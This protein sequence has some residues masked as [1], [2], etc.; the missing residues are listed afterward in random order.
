VFAKMSCC[1]GA[2]FDA[3]VR[4]PRVSPKPKLAAEV[5]WKG[6]A[7]APGPVD[8]KEPAGAAFVC[9]TAGLSS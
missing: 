4:S 3:K 9:G 8:W 1:S 2:V 5:G 7:S 6:F